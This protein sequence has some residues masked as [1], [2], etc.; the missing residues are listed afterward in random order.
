MFKVR[1]ANNDYW[2]SSDGLLRA[3]VHK[4]TVNMITRMRE[5]ELSI[6]KI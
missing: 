6:I 5:D 1:P 3:T 2:P 4:R